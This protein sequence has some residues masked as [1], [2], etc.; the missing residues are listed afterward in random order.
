M[1]NLA[2]FRA[3]AEQEAAE[4]IDMNEAVKGGGGSR[5]LPHCHRSYR[6]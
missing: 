3:L 2:Q 6:A 5:L 4:G 1:S